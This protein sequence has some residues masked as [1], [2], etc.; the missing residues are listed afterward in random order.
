MEKW[1]ANRSRTMN[2]KGSME[3]WDED[4]CTSYCVCDECIYKMEQQGDQDYEAWRQE[5]LD[6]NDDCD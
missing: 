1:L 4:E 5:Q 3:G 2:F 6:S